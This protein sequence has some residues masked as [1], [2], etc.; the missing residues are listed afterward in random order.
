MEIA[1]VL[2]SVRTAL[3]RQ[4]RAPGGGGG[5]LHAIRTRN[6]GLEKIYLA[7][8]PAYLM[9]QQPVTICD[10]VVTVLIDRL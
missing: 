9:L 4:S 2:I 5:A 3:G 7:S 1:V 10:A 8:L 6:S